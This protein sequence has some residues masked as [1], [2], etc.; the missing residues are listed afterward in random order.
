M[1]YLGPLTEQRDI[2]AAQRRLF[3]APPKLVACDIESNDLKGTDVITIGFGLPNGDNFSFALTDG[4]LPWHL[5]ML[6]DV[7]TV[8]HN[9]SYD[10]QRTALGKYPMVKLTNIEDTAMILRL[11]NKSAIELWLASELYLPQKYRTY[12]VPSV[13]EQYGVKSF[14]Q[15]PIEHALKKAAR[16]VQAT[17]QLYLKFFP[18]VPLEYY[19]TKMQSTSLMLRM[20]H[21]GIGLDSEYVDGL[22]AEI[23]PQA[24]QLK[25]S[26]KTKLGFNPNSRDEVIA[27]LESEGLTIPKKYGKKSTE[28]KDLQTLNHPWVTLILKSRKLS[29]LHSTYIKKYVGKDRMF[30]ELKLDALTGRSTSSKENIQNIPTGKRPRDIVPKFGPIRGM[31]IGDGE[32]HYLT[33]LDLSQIELRVFAIMCGDTKLQRI[34]N[35]V[36]DKA[37]DLHSIVQRHVRAQS[38]T[39]A[40]NVNFGSIYAGFEYRSAKTIA[41]GADLPADTGEDLVIEIIDFW[42]HEFPVAYDWVQNIVANAMKHADAVTLYGRK[43]DIGKHHTDKHIK[44][45]AV[46]YPVQGSA[47]EVFERFMLYIDQEKIVPPEVFGWQ[48]HDELNLDGH[49][50]EEINKRREDLEHIAEFWTPYEIEE[51]PRWK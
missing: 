17:L 45:C 4:K 18:I 32:D 37:D 40:K 33:S 14:S 38:R 15:L 27:A 8:W 28:A 5:L 35:T 1:Y 49:W 34:L 10:L 36:T 20:S 13:F 11:L 46:N 16:D 22:N 9:P 21:R 30:T 24:I 47:F 26:I 41:D 2:D 25:E 44:N 3:E 50:M 29:K 43:L 6:E 31:F 42:R 7:K 23:G 51:M 48:V 12:S 39:Q 19:R